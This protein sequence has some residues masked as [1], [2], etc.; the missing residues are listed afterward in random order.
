MTFPNKVPSAAQLKE[1]IAAAAGIPAEDVTDLEISTGRR[2]RLA[3]KVSVS[4]KA[5]VSGALADLAAAQAHIGNALA[6]NLADEMFKRCQECG[7][8]TLSNM[9]CGGKPCVQ[10]TTPGA[11]GLSNGAIAGIVIGTIAFIVMIV[12]GVT[13]SGSCK[14]N[15]GDVPYTEQAQPK[16]TVEMGTMQP[17]V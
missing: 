3:E 14:S 13:F 2:R 7:R 6:K 10:G 8:P 12:G 15:S 17:R 11:I 4:C 5:K 9:T 16:E 1:A